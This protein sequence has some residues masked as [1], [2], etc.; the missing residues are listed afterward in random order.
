MQEKQSWQC[1]WYLMYLD[2]YS[3]AMLVWVIV[4]YVILCIPVIYTELE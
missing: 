4:S 2:V 1:V 3:T